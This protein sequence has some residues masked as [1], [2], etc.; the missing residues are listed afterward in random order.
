MKTK[1]LLAP[2][3]SAAIAIPSIS[4][5]GFF[6]IS[7][8][9]LN[10][11]GSDSS[12]LQ[13][14]YL[15]ISPRGRKEA[16]FPIEKPAPPRRRRPGLLE[17][18]EHLLGLHVPVGVLERAVAAEPPV[19]VDVGQPGLVDVA[20]QHPR[21]V[22]SHQMPS[23]TRG[24]GSGSGPPAAPRRGERLLRQHLGAGA[25]LLDRGRAS[26]GVQR[27]EVALVD[28]GHR[29]DVAGA[30]ALEARDEDLAV[31]RAGAPVRRLVAVGAGGLAERLEQL[32]G[33]RHPAR[34][35]RAHQHLVAPAGLEPEEVVEAR[36]RLQVRGGDPH[37]RGGLADAL[38]GAPAVAALH[39]PERG[40]EAERI[41][42]AR[43]RRLDRLAQV[44]GQSTS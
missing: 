31:G 40:I 20:E 26:L 25:E 28:R 13:H 36:D 35:V 39:G 22:G 17:H 3:A 16:F 18:A 29:R 14:R 15:S 30:H 2:A 43:H 9:S 6:C 11:P 8:R 42:V 41:R 24:S 1:H 38:R 12:A 37:H 27:P 5:C 44:R 32:V 19:G 21:L 33:A 7:S 23:L 10:A 34:D 4:W